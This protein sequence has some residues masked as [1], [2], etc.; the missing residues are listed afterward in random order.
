MI[1]LQTIEEVPKLRIPEVLT[2]LKVSSPFESNPELK[3]CGIVSTLNMQSVSFSICA[4]LLLI[5]IAMN[6]MTHPR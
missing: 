2:P 5:A 6:S 1:L 3:T 4:V